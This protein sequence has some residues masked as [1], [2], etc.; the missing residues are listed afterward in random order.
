M[1]PSSEKTGSTFRISCNEC[2]K[3]TNFVSQSS[4]HTII[5]DVTKWEFHVSQQNTFIGPNERNKKIKQFKKKLD[6]LCIQF[7]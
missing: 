7:A 2:V 1:H 4:P 3:Y 5:L 6:S